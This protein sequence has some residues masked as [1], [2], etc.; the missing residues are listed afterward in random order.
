[1]LR[2]QWIESVFRI[3]AEMKRMQFL[4]RGHRSKLSIHP[5]ATKMYHD[6]KKLFWW[7]GYEEGCGSSLYMLV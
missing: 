4:R 2:Y 7:P 1:M 3:D 5:G 6:L